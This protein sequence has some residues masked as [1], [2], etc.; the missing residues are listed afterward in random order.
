MLAFFANEFDLAG[1][2]AIV[3]STS[4]AAEQALRTAILEGVGT[5]SQRRFV[6]LQ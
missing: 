3:A 6:L 4:C 1:A 5:R 2:A